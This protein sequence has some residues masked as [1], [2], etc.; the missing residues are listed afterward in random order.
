M[1][2]YMIDSIN[3]MFYTVFT[4]LPFLPFYLF[5]FTPTIH[6]VLGIG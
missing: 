2:C 5:T 6:A 1:N 3:G 4:V